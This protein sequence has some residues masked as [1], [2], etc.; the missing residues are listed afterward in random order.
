MAIFS[1]AILSCG[2]AE[3]TEDS[4]QTYPAPTGLG[5]YVLSSE[6]V[7]IYWDTVSGGHEGYY[8]DCVDDDAFSEYV[9][10]VASKTITG[11]EPNTTY[12][13]RVKVLG[14]RNPYSKTVSATTKLN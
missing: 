13:F 8:V 5:A 6:S 1:F 2:E 7:K 4:Y 10:Y 3:S 11:L 12:R 14:D 9:G